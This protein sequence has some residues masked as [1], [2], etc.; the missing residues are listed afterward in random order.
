M[1][2]VADARRS[3]IGWPGTVPLVSDLSLR[4]IRGNEL[5]AAQLYAILRQRSEVFVI[6]QDCN[7]LDPDGRDLEGSTTH[8]WFEGAD[9]VITSY[10]RVLVE[11]GGGHRIGRVLTPSQHRGNGLASRLMDEALEVSDRPVVLNAQSYLVGF[12]AGHGFVVDGPEF[13]EDEIPHTPMRLA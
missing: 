6:E 3:S 1:L 13:L 4:R 10:L 5:T 2:R 11:P 9:G 12:Y 8:L 7:Y